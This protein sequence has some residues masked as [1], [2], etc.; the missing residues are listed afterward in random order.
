MHI[1]LG[2]HGVLG[3]VVLSGLRRLI[4]RAN[5]AIHPT[6]LAQR[7]QRRLYTYTYRCIRKRKNKKK[8]NRRLVCDFRAKKYE[9][10][11]LIK[12]DRNNSISGRRPIRR[13]MQLYR[14]AVFSSHGPGRKQNR[15]LTAPSY[16][17]GAGVQQLFAFRE[18]MNKK[19]KNSATSP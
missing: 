3:P 19:F 12:T 1:L 4:V 17:A 2:T 6:P 8:K 10:K 18:S 14:T 16:S 7:V 11:N 5:N 13:Q 9:T 15:S